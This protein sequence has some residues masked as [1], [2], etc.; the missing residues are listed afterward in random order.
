MSFA[1]PFPDVEI[2]AASVYDYLFGNIDDAD[3]DRI[4][5][6]DAKTGEQTSYRDAVGKIDSF[7][8]ALADRGIGVGDVVGLLA[9]NST[10]FAVAFHGILRAGATATP[11]PRTFSPRVRVR[12]RSASTPQ[13]T[14]LCCPTAPARQA[15]P[16][17]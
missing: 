16:R 14:W 8:G 2:P 13:P 15:I 5:L 7:A 1:S 10:A 11:A 6:V 3:A 4:A 9:P 12:R 17:A